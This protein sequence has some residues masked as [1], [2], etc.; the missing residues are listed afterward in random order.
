MGPY[1]KKLEKDPSSSSG[2]GN[3]GG[4]GWKVKRKTSRAMGG[5]KEEEAHDGEQV[6]ASCSVFSERIGGE[7][8]PVYG[9]RCPD[10]E[11]RGS[12]EAG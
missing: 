2:A 1:P 12:R 11:G 3:G 10:G 7:W 6:L 8:I 9:A 5:K 4:G